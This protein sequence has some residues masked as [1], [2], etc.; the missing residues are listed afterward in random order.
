MFKN[1]L[2]LV[3]TL[4]AIAFG[5]RAQ[6]TEELTVELS[7]TWGSN[8]VR[9][10]KAVTFRAKSNIE[11]DLRI[12]VNDT[13]IANVPNATFAEGKYTFA[14]Q[15]DFTVTATATANGKTVSSIGYYCVPKPSV[16]AASQTV[17]PMGAFRNADGTVTFCF[18]AP[19]KETVIL[20]GSWNDYKVSQ[21]AVMDYVDG[22]ADG[23]GSYR[24][25]VKTVSGV[26]VN[27]P[28]LYYYM[29]ANGTSYKSVGDPYARLVLDPNNDKWIS[30]EVYP[31][32]I[33][34]P[35]DKVKNVCL[36]VFQDNFG[37][38]DWKV[39][40]FKGAPKDDLVIYELLF[41]DFTGTEGKANGNGTVRL[42]IEK[43]PYLKSLGINAVELLPIN[44][45]DGNLSWGYNP[46][47]YF[48]IDKAYGTAQD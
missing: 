13:E 36:A 24:Y 10:D 23:Q 34:Y 45:F 8:I 32:M 26:P 16:A 4:V 48:A 9:L 37:A 17:P 15:G 28:V 44:E 5:V 35:T 31:D 22:P 2:T 33:P 39:T 43:I 14:T 18:A 47:F 21:E 19:E 38:Y 6:E 1:Y 12:T 7:S 27:E 20:V 25:F 29:V 46:N 3:V 30:P 11:S 40:D 41:R 42:A